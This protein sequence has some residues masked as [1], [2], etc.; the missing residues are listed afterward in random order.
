[1]FIHDALK[2]LILCGE[3]EILAPNLGIVINKLSKVKDDATGFELQFEVHSPKH[4]MH[5]CDILIQLVTSIYVY[6]MQTLKKLF[7]KLEKDTFS[8]AM[9]ECNVEKNRYPDKLPCMWIIL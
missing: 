5:G 7:P 6:F 1:M 2:E 4:N 3:T 9:N 8:C